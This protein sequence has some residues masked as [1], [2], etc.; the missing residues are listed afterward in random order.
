MRK[1]L[2]IIQAVEHD[3]DV[4]IM[5]EPTDGLDPLIQQALFELLTEL[6]SR[7]RTVF[8]SSHNLSEVERL[9]DRVAI[10]RQGRLVAV[11]DVSALRERKVRRME[12]VLEQEP[13]EG[14]LDLAG[15]RSMEKRGRHLSFLVH[16]DVN[17]VLRELARLRVEDVSF[18]H[19]S[20]EEVFLEYYRGEEPN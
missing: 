13:P 10:I 8:F 1:K 19:P 15:V 17:P 4:L 7:G 5:D 3:P 18:E 14:V 11:E 6:R 2:A 12:V 16:G 9:C 20:L